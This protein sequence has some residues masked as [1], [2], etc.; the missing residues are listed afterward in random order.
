MNCQSTGASQKALIHFSTFVLVQN[1][2]K[3]NNSVRWWL[4]NS[5]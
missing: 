3:D 1:V 5:I 2:S 4:R